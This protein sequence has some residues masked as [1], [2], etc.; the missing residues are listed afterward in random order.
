MKHIISVASVLLLA[1]GLQAF[2]QDDPP[3][4][5]WDQWGQ[6]PQ[7][8]G[9][10]TTVG[11]HLNTRLENIVTESAEHR[12]QKDGPRKPFFTRKLFLIQQTLTIRQELPVPSPPFRG[13]GLG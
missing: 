5:N 10:V 12:G 4:T 8:Q 2:A 7:H 9:F 1:T 11:Q 6:N 3:S 13:R